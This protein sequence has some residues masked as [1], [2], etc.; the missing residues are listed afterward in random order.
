MPIRTSTKAT[1]AKPAAGC[2]RLAVIQLTA[3]PSSRSVDQVDRGEQ[4]DPDHVDEVPVVRH[5]NR[6]GLLLERES[7]GR[8]CSAEQEQEGDE[9][10]ADV[11]SV[12]PGG[13]EEH[14][15]VVV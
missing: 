2:R 12:E 15:P 10:A 8:E 1:T 6:A 7:F 5:D 13:E 14:R 3:L 4:P 11:Q 9:T